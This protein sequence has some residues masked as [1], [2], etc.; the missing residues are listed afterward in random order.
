MNSFQQVIQ[1][2]VAI[3]IDA[4]VVGEPVAVLG[5]DYENERRGLTARCRC[6]DGSEYAIA[7]CDVYFPERTKAADYVAAYRLW[8]GMDPYPRVSLRRRPKAVP[9]DIDMSNN[10]DLIVLAAKSNS[11]SCRVLGTDRVL[12]L[13]PSRFW[14]IVPGEILTVV[15]HRTW[16]YAGHP[17][18]SGEIKATRLDIPALGLT[19]LKLEEQGPGSQGTLLGGAWRAARAMGEA[20][21]LTSILQGQI[22]RLILIA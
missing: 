9:D 12:T 6:E 16:R 7:A 1:D 13:R 5:I 22:R 19:P 10:I 2:E 14:E 20:L 21:R 8:L 4:F 17:Y 11:L 3:P 15:P 18:L